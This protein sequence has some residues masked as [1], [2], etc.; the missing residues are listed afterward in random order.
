MHIAYLS[1]EMVPYSKTGGLADVA[2]ALPHAI[3]ERGHTVSVFT[4]YYLETR[5]V[6]PNAPQVAAGVVPVGSDLL[7]WTCHRS[8]HGGAARVYLLGNEP[9]FDRDGLYGTP[10]GDYPDSIGRFIFF[11]RAALAAAHALGEPVD[12]YHANDWQSALVPVYLRQS[13]AAHPFH[14]QS[15]SLFTIH[16]QSYQGLFWHWDWPLL[17]LPWKH[18][19]WKELE[20]YG[21]INLLKGGLLDADVLNTVSPSYAREIQTPEQGCGLEGVLAGRAADL[22]GVVNGVDYQLWSPARDALLPAR[23]SAENL[24]GKAQ[25]RTALLEHFK[26]PTDRKGPVI[27]IV[28]RL[29]EQKGF[30]LVL[31]VLEQLGRRNFQIVVLGTGA[32]KFT[33]P[34]LRMREIFPDQFG[35]ALAYDNRLAHLIYAGSDLFLMPSKFEPCGLSQLYALACGTLPVVRKTGGLSDTVVDA[36][37]DSIRAGKATGFVF[38]DYTDKALW[39]ALNRALSMYLEQPE[40][41]RKTQR[42]AMRQDWSWARSAKEYTNLYERA[43]AKHKDRMLTEP[44]L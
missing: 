18:F 33:Q 44:T 14:S 23:F 8:E 21:K 41:W 19:N 36:T 11:C 28:S 7:P 24:H 16:N 42:T 32:E 35:V 43:C 39:S 13:F 31:Q 40:I 37:P 25:C 1:S 15:A 5:K 29:V 26:L 12:V 22:F 20:F 17:N 27:G 2:G 4:P 6:E 38:E 9:F 3:A 30:D 34:F 10:H